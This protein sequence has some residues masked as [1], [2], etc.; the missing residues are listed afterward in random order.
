MCENAD[1]VVNSCMFMN[2]W[3]FFNKP[4]ASIYIVV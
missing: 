1:R 2:M 3:V 4:L